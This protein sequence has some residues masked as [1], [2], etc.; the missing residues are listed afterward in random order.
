METKSLM[1]LLSYKKQE[2]NE[3]LVEICPKWSGSEDPEKLN[4]I[5]ANHLKNHIAYKKFD[6]CR[7]CEFCNI[8]HVFWSHLEF[9]LFQSLN[10][11]G[12][13]SC[14]NK[15]IKKYGTNYLEKLKDQEEKPCQN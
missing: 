5:Q 4:R 15:Y 14:K 13:H 9:H 6:Q 8:K 2:L 10:N 1:C 3:I 11:F 12:I 7:Q